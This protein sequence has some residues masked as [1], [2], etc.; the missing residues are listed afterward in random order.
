MERTGYTIEKAS[1]AKKCQE[2]DSEVFESSKA[3]NQGNLGKAMAMLASIQN[4]V[5]STTSLAF[6]NNL[7]Y[8]YYIHK[9]CQ[10]LMSRNKGMG[11]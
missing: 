8:Q 11:V 3:F 9:K 2:M 5:R 10:V 6:K 1:Q 7:Q 4:M